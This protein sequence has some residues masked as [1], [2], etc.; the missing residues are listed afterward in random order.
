MPITF[1]EGA[2][3]GEGDGVATAVDAAGVAVDTAAGVAVI[4]GLGCCA[5]A[6]SALVAN[7]PDTRRNARHSEFVVLLFI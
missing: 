7:I 1:G 6:L 5:L 2:G 4:W 3:E